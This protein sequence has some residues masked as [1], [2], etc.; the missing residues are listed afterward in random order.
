[1]E[2][3]KQ[4]QAYI[5]NPNEEYN[6][7]AVGICCELMDSN[8]FSDAEQPLQV[9]WFAITTFQNNWR[10]PLTGLSLFIKQMDELQLNEQQKLFISQ[11]L[12]KALKANAYSDRHIFDNLLQFLESY[13][14]KLKASAQPVDAAQTISIRAKIKELVNNS[15]ESI[16]EDTDRISSEDN[17][18]I[19]TRFASLVVEKEIPTYKNPTPAT[20]NQSLP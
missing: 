14:K 19:L 20:A 2:H 4:L 15:V 13:C 1:M 10:E 5:A 12:C 3:I 17:L 11:W 8:L 7:F 9:F 16:L 18:K 6:K